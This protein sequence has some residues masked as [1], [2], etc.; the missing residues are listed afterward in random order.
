M[1]AMGSSHGVRGQAMGSVK[2]WGQLRKLS[3]HGV[4]SVN[5]KFRL[6]DRQIPRRKLAA[7]SETGAEQEPVLQGREQ[8]RSY[9]QRTLS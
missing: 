2:P 6:A 9:N 1:G 3:S 7:R 8:A 5:C 4:S